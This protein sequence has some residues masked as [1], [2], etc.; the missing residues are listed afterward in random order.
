VGPIADPNTD[1]ATDKDA[2]ILEVIN[3]LNQLSP[4]QKGPVLWPFLRN[5]PRNYRHRAID[6][7]FKSNAQHSGATRYSSRAATAPQASG[8]A[9]P[10]FFA[11]RSSG[12]NSTITGLGGVSSSYRPITQ[13]AAQGIVGQ[14]KS[15]P[16][17]V[18]LEGG[19]ADLSFIK[20]VKYLPEANAFVLNDDIVYLNPVAASE[21]SEIHRALATDDRMGVSLTSGLA[22]V[23][24]SLSSRSDVATNLELADRFLGDIAFGARRITSGYVFA[25]GYEGKSATANGN[26]AVYFNIHDFHFLESADGRLS[27]SGTSLDTTLVPLAAAAGSDGGHL[28]DADRIKKGDIPPEYV[29]NL[30]HLQANIGYYAR[31]RIIRTAIAYGEA[32]SFVR[33]LKSNGV[34]LDVSLL[35][36]GP[37]PAKSLALPGAAAPTAAT[38]S[39]SCALAVAHWTSTE[40][41]GTREAYQDHLARFPNCTFATLA[42]ARI[43]SLDAK[44]VPPPMSG[45][46]VKTC[47]RGLAMDSSGDCVREPAVRKVV[48]RRT[49]APRAATGG[50]AP[51]ALNCSDPAQI[52]A[53]ANKALSTLPH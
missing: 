30:R 38:G 23:Y 3:Y 40:S 42:A 45:P 20:S 2:E 37:A 51:P 31:E 39:E 25:P 24:G 1:D 27:R 53:C 11:G 41:I 7:L 14:Y 13:T 15:I 28:P 22:I 36:A 35:S 50:G 21:F 43:A 5:L 10:A 32:A 47:G 29:A 17:G 9:G 46:P 26:L 48:A 18:T 8:R 4:D 12:N 19:S 33:S 34:N 6:L 16:G 52:M 49:A 44:G